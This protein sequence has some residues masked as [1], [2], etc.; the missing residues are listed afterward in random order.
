MNKLTNFVSL[1][2]C[3]LVGAAGCLGGD[4]NLNSQCLPEPC[5]GDAGPTTG[6]AGTGGPGTGG[7]GGGVMGNIVGSALATFDTGLDGFVFGNYDERANLN[8][9]SSTMKGTLSHD[10]SVGN[11]S[12]GSLKAVA[13]YNG[14]NQYIDIQKQFGT[15]NPQNWAGK[16]IHVRIRASEGTFKGGAQVF[17]ITTG[18]FIFGGK[19]TNFAANS[20]WQEFTLDVSN[21]TNDD[22]ANPQSDYDPTKVIVFGVQLNTGSSGAGATPVTFNIDSFSIDP[23]IAGAT[24]TA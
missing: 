4:K 23:L 2:A 10:P 22:G 7:Q 18:T 21:P 3:L 15:G 12:P 11:P 24:G 1:S 13:P 17:A 5:V 9:G 20:N 19:F 6:S 8:G 14:A 16:T